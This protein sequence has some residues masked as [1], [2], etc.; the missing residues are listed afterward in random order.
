MLFFFI[1]YSFDLIGQGLIIGDSTV[2]DEIKSKTS[3]IY[4]NKDKTYFFLTKV[5]LRQEQTLATTITAHSSD[6]DIN[7]IIAISF[8]DKGQL[9]TEWYFLN[10][11]LIFAFESF[12]YF[13]ESAVQTGYENFKGFQAWESRYYVVDNEVKYQ[14]HKG[15][16]H[17]QENK[18]AVIVQKNGKSVLNYVIK[19]I[20]K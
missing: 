8:T 13:T 10:H 6:G 1:I 5:P 2:V 12:E 17:I 7:R 14:K 18:E 15:R 20:P 4:E 16:K 19:N 9:A 3:E 11:E